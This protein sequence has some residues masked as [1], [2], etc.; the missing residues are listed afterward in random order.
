MQ[1]NENIINRVTRIVEEEKDEMK[2]FLREFIRIET[3][4][5]PGNNYER[6]ARFL[7]EKMQL[8]GCEVQ[9]I[10]VPDEFQKKVLPDSSDSPRVSVIGKLKGRNERPLIHFSGHYDVVPAGAGWKYP[11]YEGVTKDNI[12]YGRGASDMKSGVAAQIFVLETIRRCKLELLGSMISSST[13]D[14]ETG[15]EL[16]MGYLTKSGILNKNNTDYCVITEPLDY[17]RICIGHRGTFWFKVSVKGIQSHG[18]MPSEGLNAIDGMVKILNSIDTKIKPKLNKVSKYNIS[19]PAARF[20]TLS[21]TMINAGTKVN[22]IP[23]ECSVSFDWRLIP[24]QSVE[25]AKGE[26]IE[27]CEQHKADGSIMDYSVE[28]ILEVNPTI[29]E[30]D[31]T[32]IEAFKI[33]GKKILKKEME[34]NLSPGM[35]DQRF[36]VN[37]G[38]LTQAIVYGPGR[39]SEAH[40]INESIN[41]NEFADAVKIMTIAVLDLIGFVE[42]SQ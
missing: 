24:D 6:C 33:A 11:P 13:P 21:S 23:N 40:K 38:G 5:P 42:L 41:M 29:V 19:P 17:D 3:E 1:I 39:L 25:W 8:L 27:I 12:V 37:E 15:G 10:K 22:T 20:S 31:Q 34:I 26:I 35:D 2:E 32:L 30:E 9:Y 16:G 4:N 14:E 7:G 28:S 36:V 18:S